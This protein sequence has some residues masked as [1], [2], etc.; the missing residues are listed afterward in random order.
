LI[1]IQ[2]SVEVAGGKISTAGNGSLMGHLK[3]P[4]ARRASGAVK[5]PA[6]TVNQYEDVLD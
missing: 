3:D 1:H 6:Q 4:E 2:M 5:S